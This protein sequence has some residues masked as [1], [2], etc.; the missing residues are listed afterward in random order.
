MGTKL[1]FE[2]RKIRWDTPQSTSLPRSLI[3]GFCPAEL[4][5]NVYGTECPKHKGCATQAGR[6]RRKCGHR[7]GWTKVQWS[8]DA[9]PPV[10][11][12]ATVGWFIAEAKMMR[13]VVVA[14]VTLGMS[15]ASAPP[16]IAKQG[17]GAGMHINKKKGVCV[18]NKKGRAGP[19]KMY[20]H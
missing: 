4:Q 1:P 11:A 15:L 5:L 10:M 20:M 17:C 19:K 2:P 12:L 14:L 13:F 9:I 7:I 6:C 18:V 8:S 16:V 3:E